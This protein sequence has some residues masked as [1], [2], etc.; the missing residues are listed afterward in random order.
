MPRRRRLGLHLPGPVHPIR[1]GEGRGRMAGHGAGRQRWNASSEGADVGHRDQQG[2]RPVRAELH[3]VPGPQRRQRP[4]RRRGVQYGRGSLPTRGDAWQLRRPDGIGMRTGRVPRPG[5]RR[6]R[7]LRDDGLVARRRD[8]EDHQRL[9]HRRLLDVGPLGR[10][11]HDGGNIARPHHDGV[12]PGLARPHVRVRP[13]QPVHLY[14]G[15]GLPHLGRVQRRQ[16]RLQ[17]AGYLPPALGRGRVHERVQVGRQFQ[18]GQQRPAEVALHVEPVAAGHRQRPAGRGHGRQRRHA[19]RDLRRVRDHGAGCR[20]R[21][22][23]RRQREPA[24][25][26]PRG[27]H[28]LHPGDHGAAG[29]LAAVLRPRHV[30]EH[31]RDAARR[32]LGGLVRRDAAR[33]RP[34]GRGRAVRPAPARQARLPGPALQPVQAQSGGL[35][36]GAARPSGRPQV[37]RRQLAPFRRRVRRHQRT[38]RCCSSARGRAAPACTRSTSRIRSSDGP[39]ATGRPDLQ[40]RTTA[41]ARPRPRPSSRCGARRRTARRARRSSTSS[42]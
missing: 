33:D 11:L 16:R 13:P 42:R 4:Q 19:R 24:A 5:A 8:Q 26:E 22:G 34:Q 38:R 31:V 6:L 10:E 14:Q 37:R 20:L 21:H 27:D 18:D 17:P 39:T 40:T 29:A 23:E 12:V 15:R 35:R 32:Q 41:T 1:R 36:D 28:Q 9:R 2:R 25:V 7:L 3:G 30:R